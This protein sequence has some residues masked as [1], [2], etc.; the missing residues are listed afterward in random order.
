MRRHNSGTGQARASRARPAR[1]AADRHS[2][3]VV[4]E[5]TLYRFDVATRRLTASI[6]LPGLTVVLAGGVLWAANLA[7]GPTFVYRIDARSG[8][9][10]SKQ[11]GDTEIVGMAAGAG[12][13]CAGSHDV[14]TLL[15]ID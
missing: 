7:E 4:G 3:W 1:L 15:R 8:T 11:P 2:L 12:A 9:I 10:Q 6:P 14:G 5:L 13:V